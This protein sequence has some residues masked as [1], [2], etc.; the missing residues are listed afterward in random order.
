[1]PTDGMEDGLGH[2]QQLRSGL[3]DGTGGTGAGETNRLV[4]VRIQAE[5]G[6]GNFDR[7][8]PG[9]IAEADHLALAGTVDPMRID[10]QELSGKMAAGAPQFAQGEL[11]ALGLLRNGRRVNRG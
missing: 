2:L 11:E 3:R 6:L 5:E 1:M 8:E 10:G 7:L 9:I 4:G